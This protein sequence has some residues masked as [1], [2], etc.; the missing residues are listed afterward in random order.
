MV[1]KDDSVRRDEETEGHVSLVAYTQWT[2][3]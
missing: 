2:H 3:Q 1:L